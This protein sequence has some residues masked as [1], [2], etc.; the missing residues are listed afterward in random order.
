MIVVRFKVRARPERA[1]EVAATLRDVIAA[2]RPLA[3]VISFDIGRDLADPATFIATEVFE[4]REAL[5]RQEALPAV[6][7]AIALFG[8]AAADEPEETIYEVS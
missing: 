6:Q 7:K 1:E 8:E 3:G 4:D 2:T 5:A